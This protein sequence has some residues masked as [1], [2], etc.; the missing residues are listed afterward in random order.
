LVSTLDRVIVAR[1][2]PVARHHLCADK[3]YTGQPAWTA[4]VDDGFGRN[5]ECQFTEAG[6]DTSHIIWFSN[7]GKGKYATDKKD[8]LMNGIKIFSASVYGPSGI[9]ALLAPYQRERHTGKL[10]MPTGGVNLKIAA[11]FQAD[12]QARLLPHPGDVRSPGA[13]DRAEEDR[14]PAHD[15]R[16]DGQVQGRVHPLQARVA[17][18]GFRMNQR[19]RTAPDCR[20]LRW[21]P[22]S[23][24]EWGAHEWR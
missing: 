17:R 6:V 14:R 12:Q 19:S 11:G 13:G 7:S 16:V 2:V 10:V 24:G 21:F 18:P 5:I 15:S 9:G 23:S 22:P 1:P 20:R 3:G 8:S 4:M